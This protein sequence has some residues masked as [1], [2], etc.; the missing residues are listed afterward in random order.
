M[1]RINIHTIYFNKPSPMK[2][3]IVFS[4]LIFTSLLSYSQSYLG[5]ITK[6]ANFREGPGTAYNS[7]G[8]LKVGTQIF[9][10]S[11]YS[12]NDFYN[13]INIATDKEGYVH[14]SYVEVG[15]KIEKNEQGMFQPSGQTE[16]YNPKIQ[17]YN[18]TKLKLT[19]KLNNQ[20]Y[21]FS[22]QERKTITMTPGSCNYRASAPGVIPNIGTEIMQSNQGYTWEFYI[23]AER[24]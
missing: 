7:I 5:K 2:I 3:L 22:Q 23:T 21:S 20:I 6:Q 16:T 13:I 24:Y 9:I 1:H 18:N 10:V 12:D 19:L 8:T 4:I 11:R 17:I 15:Q 14:K